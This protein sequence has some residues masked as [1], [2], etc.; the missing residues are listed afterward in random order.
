MEEDTPFSRERERCGPRER[1]RVTWRGW[2][3]P[4]KAPKEAIH[5]CWFRP[6]RNPH[7]HVR[8]HVG[9]AGAAISSSLRLQFVYRLKKIRN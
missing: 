8:R 1:E 5:G 9:T 2:S 3:S 6:V 4:P 7:V